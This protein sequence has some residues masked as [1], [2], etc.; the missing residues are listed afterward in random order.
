[1]YLPLC[2][3]MASWQRKCLLVTAVCACAAALY[4]CRR[5]A[6][7]SGIPEVGGHSQ[8]A[9]GIKRECGVSLRRGRRGQ[10][11]QSLLNEVH[12]NR[13]PSAPAC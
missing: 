5:A 2:L 6:Y 9:S 1:M 3:D 10:V 13:C 7:L 8:D 11:L 4:F 12:V